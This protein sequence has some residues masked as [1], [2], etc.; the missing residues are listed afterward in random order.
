MVVFVFG[1]VPVTPLLFA[2]L[3]G[4]RVAMGIWLVLGVIVAAAIPW[5]T[6]ID[7]NGMRLLAILVYVILVVRVAL[8]IYGD[9]SAVMPAPPGG[10]P[11]S[12]DEIGLTSPLTRADALDAGRALG[13][14]EELMALRSTNGSGAARQEVPA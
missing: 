5:G 14:D 9:L 2:P 13:I 10:A 4:R 6:A 7:S 3:P 11:S 1:L 8:G 12:P